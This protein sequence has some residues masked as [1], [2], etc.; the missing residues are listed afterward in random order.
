M[1]TIAPAAFGPIDPPAPWRPEESTAWTSAAVGAH[2]PAPARDGGGDA[3]AGAID[4]DRR[5]AR[6]ESVF[7]AGFP[8]VFRR[9]APVRPGEHELDDD[10]RLEPP[11]I[12]ARSGR[13]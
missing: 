5:A 3:N 12:E 2:D 10:R 1:A 11:A 6:L 13:A 7:E 9:M 8:Q 4:R